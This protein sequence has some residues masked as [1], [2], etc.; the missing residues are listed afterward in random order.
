MD[1]DHSGGI[2]S[3]DLVSSRSSMSP[4][5]SVSP[6]TSGGSAPASP[7]MNR[8]SIS[9]FSQVQLNALT[10][11]QSVDDKVSLYL[12]DVERIAEQERG[13]Q[14]RRR[15][16]MRNTKQLV[17]ESL[18]LCLLIGV[19]VVFYSLY[20]D[21]SFVDSLYFV[22]VTITSV[23]Y[24]DLLPSDTGS[25]MFTVVYILATGCLV[26]ISAGRWVSAATDAQGKGGTNI[27]YC[28]EKDTEH[29]WHAAARRKA[30]FAVLLACAALLVL[31]LFFLFGDD[32]TDFD[33]VDALYLSIMTATTIGYGD[34]SPVSED[35]RLVCCF[36]ILIVVVFFANAI[37]TIARVHQD[38]H[39][40]KI[41]HR[42]LRKHITRADLARYGG[43]DGILDK[44]EFT[45]MK[46]LV[47]ERICHRDLIDCF[48]M[49]EEMDTDSSG[50][51]DHVDLISQNNAGPPATIAEVQCSEQPM[52]C[53]LYTSPSPRDRT[54]SRMPSSA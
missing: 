7:D 33:L 54:R 35:A 26:A 27:S 25:K 18:I 47:Q 42:K 50:F 41:A 6:H 22:I 9:N 1:V 37:Q 4:R 44:C 48:L 10:G 40:A 13:M 16:N 17:C 39:L 29:V 51:L 12:N 43:E 53:L 36:L 3:R 28:D 14:E 34:I 52:P 20:E 5:S 38:A 46:L 45:A 19:G 32:E 31:T 11:S 23:G 15:A 8:D 24:G 30:C 2:D 49:F 21:W